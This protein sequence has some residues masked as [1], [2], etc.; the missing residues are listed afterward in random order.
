MRSSAQKQR[1]YYP[2]VVTTDRGVMSSKGN[3]YENT[4]TR[5]RMTP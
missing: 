3:W 2:P 1:G 4:Y 5:T